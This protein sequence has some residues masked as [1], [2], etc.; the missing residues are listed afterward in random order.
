MLVRYDTPDS[1]GE[2]RRQRNE[3]FDCSELNP[4]IQPPDGAEH[5]LAWF[6]DLSSARSHGFNGPDPIRLSDIVSWSTLTGEIITREEVS[7][8][9]RM[10]AAFIGTIAEEQR[11]QAERERDKDG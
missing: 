10:D 3:R 2:T 4:E 6:W 7:I 9:R 8:L 5:L 1:K 11:A